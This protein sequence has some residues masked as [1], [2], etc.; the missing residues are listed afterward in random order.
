MLDLVIVGS[1]Y[2]GSVLAARLAGQ[3][4]VL[5]LE[6]GRR[7]SSG[8]F[9]STLGGVARAYASRRNPLGLWGMRL[10]EGTGNGF[11]SA[12]GGASVVNYGITSYPDAHVFARWPIGAAELEPYFA[13][14]R[15]TLRPSAN[16][17]ADELLDKR[18]LDLV[19]P[20][21]R[22]DYEN[23]I[24][25]ERCTL[26]GHCCPGCNEG[27][28][29][30]LDRTYLAE[31]EARGAELRVQTE[32]HSLAPCA[33]GSWE[34]MVAPTGRPEEL[35]RIVARRVALCAGAFGTLDLLFRCHAEVPVSPRFG[36]GMSMNGDG[37]AFLYNTALPISTHHGAPIST[38]VRLHMR[39]DEG[40]LRTLT[41]MAGRIP[42]SALGVA[43]RALALVGTFVGERHA[44]ASEV[45]LLPRA[46]R[47]WRDLGGILEGGALSQSFMYKL[48]GQDSA[49][50]EAIFDGEGRAAIHWPDYAED[51]INR[52]AA[53]RLAEWADRIG[54]ILV[55]N[56]GTWRF[57]R[58][59]GVHPLGGARMGRSVAEGVVDSFGRVYRPDGGTYPGLRIADASIIPTSVGVP[60]SFTIAA[61]AERIAEDLGAELARARG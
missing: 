48:D 52:F 2:G 33:D 4:R 39:D 36:E 37:L 30:S 9:P 61:V 51:P 22:V 16:P 55:P 57:M 43:G 27:A 15:A 10:A 6:R 8:E 46:R 31:A 49:R 19:E 23:T 35:E 44:G 56:L 11:V 3:G 53:A 29:L 40:Q 60:P 32:V 5:L 41:V 34:L 14:A 18:F 24:D 54:G 45:R 13:R 58:S 42:F 38:T 7:W 59:F 47:R 1:G 26:C 25:W 50:G 17:R 28:K 20:G 21:R 12:L